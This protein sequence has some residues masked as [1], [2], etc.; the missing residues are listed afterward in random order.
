MLPVMPTAN[1][2]LGEDTRSLKYLRSCNLRWIERP[3][4]DSSNGLTERAAGAV[5]SR[6]TRG[7]VRVDC[8]RH[9]REHEHPAGLARTT[10]GR[11]DDELGVAIAVEIAGPG[12]A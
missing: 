11:T 10:G 9:P 4:R 6:H 1:T 2:W 12:D 3:T 7:V 5:R 8:S